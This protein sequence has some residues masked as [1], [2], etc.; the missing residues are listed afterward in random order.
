LWLRHTTL[1]LDIALDGQILFD[2]L[3]YAADRLATLRG[4]LAEAGL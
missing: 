2:P 3:A 4:L 1:L